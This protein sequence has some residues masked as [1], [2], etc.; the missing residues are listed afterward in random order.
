MLW[1]CNLREDCLETT[2]SRS[3]RSRTKRGNPVTISCRTNGSASLDAAQKVRVTK[4]NPDPGGAP[5]HRHP[6][7]SLGNAITPVA[8]SVPR[9]FS[10]RSSGYAISKC[11][12]LERQRSIR[13]G[14]RRCAP[15]SAALRRRTC[16]LLNR[17]GPVG[18][19]KDRAAT[20]RY[21][22]RAGCF[23]A[24]AASKS[25]QRATRMNSPRLN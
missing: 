18:T 25:K 17:V 11:G 6:P 14:P 5:L 15:Y 16:W 9:R 13:V 23:A 21:Q 22:V 2:V 12:C 4:S 20:P 24:V 10:C 7:A 19:S 8:R 3:A 1:E